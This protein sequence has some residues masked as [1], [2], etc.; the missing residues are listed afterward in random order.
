ML[1][2]WLHQQ[3]DRGVLCGLRLLLVAQSLFVLRLRLLLG[4]VFLLLFLACLENSSNRRNP[5]HAGVAVDRPA[6]VPTDVRRS[7]PGGGLLLLNLLLVVGRGTIGPLQILL[8]KT[9]P[10]P[11]LPDMDGRLEVLLAMLALP[12]L[13]T[14]GRVLGRLGH[15]RGKSGIGQVLVIDPLL[16][17]VLWMTTS[18]VLS[19]RLTLTGMIHSSLSWVS[20]GA[21]MAWKSLQVFHQLVARLLLLQLMV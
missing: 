4:L 5:A 1:Q 9:E 6:M 11:L 10:M 2:A 21:F 18:L 12:E 3:Q 16:L 14:G 7:A 19:S 13:M 15:S 20:S 8:R 17:R